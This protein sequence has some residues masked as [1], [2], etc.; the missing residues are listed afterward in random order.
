MRPRALVSWSGGKDCLLAL[1]EAR[2]HF[3][4][5]ALVTT[6]TADFQRISMHGVRL[7]LLQQQ[8]D[9]LG[10]PLETVAIPYPC[11]NAEYEARMR[12]AFE[13]RRTAGVSKVI[14]GDIFLED[15]RRYREERLFGADAC[16]FP[17]WKRDSRQLA[18]D[19]VAQGFRAVV[20][21]VDT[22]ALDP[23]FAGRLYDRAFLEDLPPG[24]DPCGENGEFHT[25]AFAGPPFAQPVPFERGPGVLR[26][27]RFFYCDL[28][29]CTSVH[30]SAP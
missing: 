20:C 5:V 17:L 6:I 27:K 24:V 22:Q 23:S 30:A 12:A 4:V 26:E 29:P 1:W 19:F 9:A 16:V 2:A 21:C 3:D 11:P 13:R 14:C 8:A 28:L 10:V 25:F 18:H 15:V 7:E